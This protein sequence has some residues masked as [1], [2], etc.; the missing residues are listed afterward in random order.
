MRGART[1]PQRE[2]RGAAAV[3]F[4]LVLLPLLYI[5]F[6]IIQY[7]LYF[8]AYQGGSDV[9]RSAARVAAVGEQPTCAAFRS[10]I[11]AQIDGLSG[12]VEPADIDRVYR[13]Q[14]PT[15]VTVGD[16]VT[17]TVRF[18]SVDMHLPFIPFISDGWVES[19]AR[20]RVDYVPV[21]PE[22]CP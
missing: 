19:S 9:T 16:T 12:V 1:R 2:D 3:E 17:V 6:G 21:A 4:A 20:A 7:G 10:D 22:A 14:D 8:W 15:R 11:A 13:Q 18:K 5:V